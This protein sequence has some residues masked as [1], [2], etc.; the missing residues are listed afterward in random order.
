MVIVGEI[1]NKLM[2]G[3]PLYK[4]PR[5]V[6]GIYANASFLVEGSEHDSDSHELGSLILLQLLFSIPDY[7]CGI[8]DCDGIFWYVPLHKAAGADYGTCA[9]LSGRKNN[10][11]GAYQHV[12]AD[13]YAV[14]LIFGL[15]DYFCV[16]F[17]EAPR[18]A[19]NRACRPEPHKVADYYIAGTG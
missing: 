14:W 16:P 15:I 4:M 1:E 11:I 13:Y 18:P 10:C 6:S 17:L 3:S 7:S 12:V 8:A 19:N 5:D 2:L 9:Y